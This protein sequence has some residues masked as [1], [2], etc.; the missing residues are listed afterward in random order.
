MKFNQQIQNQPVK[1]LDRSFQVLEEIAR[2]HGEASLTTLAKNL[3]LPPSTIHRILSSLIQLGYVVQNVKNGN[4][5]LGLK[6]LHLSRSVLEN[7][8]IRD[9]AKEILKELMEKTGETANLVVLDGNEAVYIEKAES[10]SSVRYFSLIGQRA[11]LSVTGVGKVLLSEMARHDVIKILKEKGMPKLTPNSITD[12]NTFLDELDRVKKQGYAFDK[13]ECE[14]GARCVAA[15]VR[16]H[17][18]RIVAAISVSGPANRI[19]LEKLNELTNTIKNYALKISY[20]LGYLE[21]N[22]N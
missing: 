13:E 16:D 12:L 3:Q 21:E 5:Y 18:G 2:N 4:Y 8:N 10:H 22:F 14:L 6:I 9:I 11:P 20:E 19:T 15:P 1:S 7:L 17:T